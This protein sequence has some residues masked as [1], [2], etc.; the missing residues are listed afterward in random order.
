MPEVAIC[1]E[2]VVIPT[3]RDA[4]LFEGERLEYLPVY[5]V[6]HLSASLPLLILPLLRHI[7]V[8]D[9]NR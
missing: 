2:K 1:T 7:V 8:L 5:F 3:L 6:Q 4:I 9:Q